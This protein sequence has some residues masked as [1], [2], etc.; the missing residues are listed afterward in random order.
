M[1]SRPPPW[2]FARRR[3]AGRP[4]EPRFT[5]EELGQLGVDTGSIPRIP[6]EEFRD[7]VLHR[8]VV[9]GQDAGWEAGQHASIFAPTGGGKTYLIRHGLLPL[10]Q[11]YPVLWIQF[12]PRDGTMDGWGRRAHEYPGWDQRLRY[13]FRGLRSERWQRD[14]EHFLVRLPA[15]R[16]S[17]TTKQESEAWQRAR[18][19]AGEA[20]DRA[21]REGGWVVVI[22]EVRALADGKAPALSLSSVLE[23][24][25]QRGRSQPLT[26]IAGTQ[27]PASA[28]SSMY[29]Q[30]RWVFFGRQ[31]DIG[32]H[33]RIGE[34]G[35]D[36]EAVR[37][38]LPTLKGS[39]DP[40]GPEFLAVDRDSGEMWITKVEA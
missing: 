7:D 25:W 22:D 32:R 9:R 6:W 2:V 10:W 21:Y 34:I 36:V 30:P 15:Y 23:N 38:A 16:W 20:L 18:R 4:P 40:D 26:V 12:K 3:T 33:E 5:D 14:P 29:D 24:S 17:N 31:L 13:R 19:I 35:G 27:Q 37:A 11:K 39:R 28:P 8:K 1:A